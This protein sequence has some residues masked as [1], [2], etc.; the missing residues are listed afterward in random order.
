MEMSQGNTLYSYF[1]YFFSFSLKKKLCFL[2]AAHEIY[3]NYFV[4]YFLITDYKGDKNAYF[5]ISSCVTFSW[6]L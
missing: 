2:I 5:I 1:I 3:F 6:L 4:T